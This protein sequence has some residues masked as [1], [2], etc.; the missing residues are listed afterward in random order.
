M[1]Y[2][3]VQTRLVGLLNRRDLTDTLRDSFI[4][5]SIQRVQRKLRIPAMEKTVIATV[6]S[7]DGIAIP[8]DLLELKGLTVSGYTLDHRSL[9]E[10][11]PLE[12]IQGCPRI[13][14]RQGPRWRLAPYPEDGT[15][16]RIDYWAEVNALV[17]ATDTNT[18]TLIAGDL[19]VY[20][21]LSYAADYFI[22]ERASNFEARFQQI[23]SDL[24]D[25]SDRDAL[26]DASVSP[27]YSFPPDD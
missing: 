1:N 16:V 24:Q 8:S 21:A 26:A 17:N 11:L 10:V 22:D 4:D 20:G 18:L 5:Q 15:V 23:L 7:Y 6:E 19:I 13:F 25:Q 3:D 9:A 27:V 14:A 12:Q 2:G